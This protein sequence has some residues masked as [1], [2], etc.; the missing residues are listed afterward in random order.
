MGLSAIYILMKY[1]GYWE[2]VT[3]LSDWL[4]NRRD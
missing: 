1:C 2:T 3:C 4:C